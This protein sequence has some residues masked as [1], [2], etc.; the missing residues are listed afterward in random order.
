MALRDT[1]PMV[2]VLKYIF[3]LLLVFGRKSVLA[4]KRDLSSYMDSYE[5]MLR[6]VLMLSASG[7]DNAIINI[8][9]A[10]STMSALLILNAYV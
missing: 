2:L 6:Q 10:A 4:N 5:E 7:C 3:Y 1:V 8:L 9:N